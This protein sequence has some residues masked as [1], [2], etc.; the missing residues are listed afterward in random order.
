MV[1]FSI[2]FITVLEVTYSFRISLFNIFSV[3]MYSVSRITRS[4]FFDVRF[5]TL[6]AIHLYSMIQTSS[7]QFSSVSCYRSEPNSPI[8]TEAIDCCNNFTSIRRKNDQKL[9]TLSNLYRLAFCTCFLD[10]LSLELTQSVTSA[11]TFPASLIR[12]LFH[13]I[14]PVRALLFS[15]SAI[16]PVA[17]RSIRQKRSKIQ[18]QRKITYYT[19]PAKLYSSLYHFYSAN[20]FK[21]NTKAEELC[22][23]TD[24]VTLNLCSY[25]SSKTNYKYN[26]AVFASIPKM[27]FKESQ[28]AGAFNQTELSTQLI[29]LHTPLRACIITFQLSSVKSFRAFITPFLFQKLFAPILT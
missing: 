16:L 2:E 17:R 6:R 8:H 15:G 28:F 7:C 9:I 14:V 25:L 3:S 1:A 24:T 21:M 18:L 23:L 26:I 4:S 10:Q 29:Q 5:S 19:A 20:T 13:T 22:S 12:N 11:A 27:L